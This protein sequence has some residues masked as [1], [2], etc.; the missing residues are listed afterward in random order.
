MSE[1]QD[2]DRDYSEPPKLEWDEQE[3]A[4]HAYFWVFGKLERQRVLDNEHQPIRDPDAGERAL[5]EACKQ[6]FHWD[7]GSWDPDAPVVFIRSIAGRRIMKYFPG[8]H[9][10]R[11]TEL[12]QM[13]C[14]PDEL[15]KLYNY[16]W[17]TLLEKQLTK[18]LLSDWSRIH[19]TERK[20]DRRR[21]IGTL[22]GPCQVVSI[23]ELRERRERQRRKQA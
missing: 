7:R 15:Q 11:F 17:N 23:A 13:R 6:Q 8:L 21:E 1:R 16:V 22:E 2:A 20:I 14:S 4:W 3:R 19:V 18:K 5:D 12:L 9:G 10:E